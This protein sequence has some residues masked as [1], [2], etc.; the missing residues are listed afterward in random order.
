MKKPGHRLRCRAPIVRIVRAL[1]AGDQR[2]A[3]PGV[4]AADGHI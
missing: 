1:L 2:L 4:T 3:T